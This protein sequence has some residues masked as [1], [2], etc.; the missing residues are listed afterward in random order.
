V[1]LLFL[2]VIVLFCTNGSASA[3]AGQSG[4]V[5]GGLSS[6]TRAKVSAAV[7]DK[8]VHELPPEGFIVEFKSEYIRSQ[9]DRD[10]L[11]LGLLH[12]DSAIISQKA[13]AFEMIKQRALSPFKERG[14]LKMRSFPHLPLVHVQ[15]PNLEVLRDLLDSDAVVG[16]YPNDMHE[17][18]LT[19]SL[20]LIG[21]TFVGFDGVG[22]TVA[23]LDTGVDYARGEFGSCSAPGSPAGC[24]VIHAQDF[25]P[26]D[27][28]RDA[29][30]HGTF[31]SGIIAGVA[32]G[33]RIAALDVFDGSIA[34]ASDVISAIDWV[35]TNKETYNIVAI[36]LS[37]GNG[38]P[39]YNE[40]PLSWATTPFANA[41][42]AGV[43]PIVSSGNDG[44][45][46][47]LSSPA[48]APGAIRVGAVYDDSLGWVGWRD[49]NDSGTA[50]DKVTCFSNSADI[51][52]LFAPGAI[53]DAVGQSGGGT[54]LAAPHVSGGVAVLRGAFPD[55]TIQQTVDRIVRTGVM[56]TDENDQRGLPYITKPR[57]DLSV[58]VSESQVAPITVIGHTPNIVTDVWYKV[59]LEDGFAAPPILVTSLESN[60]GGDTAG[61]RIRN[62]QSTSFEV[63]VEEEQSNDSELAHTTERVGYL[64]TELGSITDRYGVAIGEAGKINR[65][66]TDG[67]QWHTVNLVGIYANPV[68]IM[69]M[70]TVSGAQPAHIRLRDV[71]TSSFKFQIEE[72]DYLDGLH[73]A[74]E[75]HYIVV[76]SGYYELPGGR[77]VEAGTIQGDHKGT[78]VFLS[79]GLSDAVVLS[80]SQTYKG[81]QAIVTRQSNTNDSTLALRV[82]EE[83]GNDGWHTLETIGYIVIK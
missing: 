83:E 75:S 79:V 62:L 33:A 4:G 9:A 23:V 82:Q 35:I 57:L 22:T 3:R 61:R 60:N 58:A 29:I 80:Q 43:L 74:E 71:G 38:S 54:S 11:A 2:F 32:P 17:V 1:Q 70:V 49:C 56:V 37:L 81:S 28:S 51:L 42:A 66:Q 44:F 25:A 69:N 59:K 48:C 72:W 41:R 34:W 55:E 5:F 16:V 52:T 68:V 30:G 67:N 65:S 78:T 53:I 39:N 64:A 20:P 8:V 46:N 45:P 73:V 27:F 18:N 76:E 10:R 7:I 6:T 77:R 12:E 19:E 14:I 50:A 47:A 40:C 13:A 31:V 36:N 63:Q 15:I 21:Q 24:K 26:E